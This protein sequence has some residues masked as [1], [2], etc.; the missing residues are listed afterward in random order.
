[1]EEDEELT[2]LISKLSGCENETKNCQ[3]EWLKCDKQ[4]ESSGKTITDIIRG[5]RNAEENED[6]QYRRE[7]EKG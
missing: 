7:P 2:S 1:M 3:E 6:D 5:V 4:E